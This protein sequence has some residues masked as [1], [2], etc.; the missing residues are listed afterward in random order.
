LLAANCGIAN[1][2]TSDAELCRLPS[3]HFFGVEEKLKARED[4]LLAVPVT[5]GLASEPESI[6]TASR[7][8]DASRE[9]DTA[10]NDKRG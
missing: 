1:A 7:E 4:A 9:S 6:C 10:W 8:C 5:A 3:C 2:L